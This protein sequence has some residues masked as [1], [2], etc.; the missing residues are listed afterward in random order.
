[1]EKTSLSPNWFNCA[2]C[3][4][5][6]FDTLQ[7]ADE[8]IWNPVLPTIRYEGE[9]SRVVSGKDVFFYMA[10]E[11]N[12][13]L[14]LGYISLSPVSRPIRPARPS[15]NGHHNSMNVLAQPAGLGKIFTGLQ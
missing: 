7:A 9:M 2:A 3:G 1:M 10:A 13:A 12:P 14:P 15:R 4:P 11:H 5:G 6:A 8:T